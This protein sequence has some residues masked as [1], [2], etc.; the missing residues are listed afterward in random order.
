MS[1]GLSHELTAHFR[2][3]LIR[4]ADPQCVKTAS[5]QGTFEYGPAG[6]QFRRNRTYC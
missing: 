4:A 6:L 1:R 3:S 5:M 2:E